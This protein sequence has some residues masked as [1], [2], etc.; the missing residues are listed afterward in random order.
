[1]PVSK[2]QIDGAFS[3]GKR[4]LEHVSLT[5]SACSTGDK[6]VKNSAVSFVFLISAIQFISADD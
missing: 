6:L 3:S 2:I 5:H 4:S 1:M